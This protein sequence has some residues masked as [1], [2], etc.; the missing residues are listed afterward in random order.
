[1]RK[2]RPSSRADYLMVYVPHTSE[3]RRG[4]RTRGFTLV[5]LMVVIAMIAILASLAAPSWRELLARNA[6]RSAVNDLGA[7]LQYARS[8]AV[9]LN[10]PIT[11]C[12]SNDAINCANTGFENGWIVR[13]GAQVN[14][15][16]NQQLLQDTLPRN[17]VRMAGAGMTFPRLTFL[18]NGLPSNGFIGVTIAACPADADLN[19]ITRTMVINR[20][21]R[22]RLEQPGICPL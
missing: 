10:S 6:I 11:V 8:E 21:G 14:D 15:P 1:M 18:P 5:E 20:T 17:S 19:A 12:A 7:S 13:T 3:I 4:C 22:I 2:P 9:R 16:V